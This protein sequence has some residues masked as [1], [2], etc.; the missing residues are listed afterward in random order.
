M[1]A[2]Q[3]V[4]LIEQFAAQAP[5]GVFI[6]DSRGISIFANK[7]LH[8]MFQIHEHPSGALGYDVFGDSSFEALGLVSLAEKARNGEQ[9]DVVVDI[10]RPDS[11]GAGQK[12][13]RKEAITVRITCYAL[14][15]SAQ[16]IEHYVLV[17]SDVTE[18]ARHRE[19]LRIQ[20]HGLAIYDKSKEARL[21]RLR[22][23]EDGVVRLEK[24]IRSRG[25]EPVA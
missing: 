15:S 13:G 2:A 20:M 16:K 7:K 22:E 25:A 9:I 6:T 24:E 23:L 21:V 5:F 3:A 8:E 1:T 17:I 12:I 4:N 19:E 11:L 10:P 18:T 14:R